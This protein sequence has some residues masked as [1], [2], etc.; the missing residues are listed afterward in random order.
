[1]REINKVHIYND[2]EKDILI[3][4]HFNGFHTTKLTICLKFLPVG[5]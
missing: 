2:S 5:G 3:T 1:M 4:K